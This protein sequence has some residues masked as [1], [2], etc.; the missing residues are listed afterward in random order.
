[1]VFAKVK[2]SYGAKIT[3]AVLEHD[4]ALCNSLRI[5]LWFPTLDNRLVCGQP[6]TT[7]TALKS[8]T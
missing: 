7:F 4:E 6:S 3:N 5:C 1:M 2:L 8:A